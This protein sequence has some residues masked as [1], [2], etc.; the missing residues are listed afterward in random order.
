MQ[1]PT[2]TPII[3]PTNFPA[4]RIGSINELVSLTVPVLTIIATLI[5]G[6]LLMSASYSIITAGGDPEKIESAKKTATYAI[7]GLF[8]IVVAFLVVRLLS[9]V[10]NLEIFI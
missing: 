4:S 1:T 7:I 2:P 6:A 8:L 5:F 3:N 10:F 9:F